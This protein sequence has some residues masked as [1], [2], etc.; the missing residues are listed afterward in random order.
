MYIYRLAHAL[1][2]EGHHVDVVHCV[3]SYHLFHREEP[4]LSF[5]EHPNVTRHE[6]RSRYGWLSPLLTQQT[7]L[8][9]L[10]SGKIQE[11][12]KQKRYDVIHFHNISLLGPQLMK[13]QPPSGRAVKIY[14][15]H[16]HWLICPTHVL[17]KFNRQPCD[18]PQCLRCTLMS[19]R[20]PQ[21]WRYLGVLEN[22]S[23]HVDQFV[24]PSRFTAQMHADRGFS[25]PVDYLPHFIDKKDSD[26]QTPRP[27][28]QEKP[29]FL[30]V[31]RLEAIKGAQTL[32]DFWKQVPE[33]D[34]LIVG[35]GSQIEELKS[36]ASPHAQIKFLGALSQEALGNY[37]YHALATIV[38]SLTYETFGMII[39][40]SF[41]RKTPVIVRDLGAL[42]EVVRESG[43]GRIYQ[44]DTD[45]LESIQ[46]IAS[47]RGLREEL[48][49]RGY[50]A[51]VRNWTREPH[52]ERYFEFLGR[53]AVTVF[54][55][56]PWQVAEYQQ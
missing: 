30:F 14:T 28:P 39:L 3:D 19:K 35:T 43:G 5:K 17:W 4:E 33:Y 12:L 25:R 52:L 49:E 38:P 2:D 53:A 42:P 51:F 47:S 37:Y 7:G 41:A 36:L 20:P 26:W 11:I 27:R 50:Q 48:G 34:L 6:L 40:E 31:G 1:G 32:V 44:T 15:T 23:R 56:I 9:L 24:S 29:Y 21:L 10:K 54:G 8:P 55:Q 13:I 22:A 16:E 45:L 46:Q 18:R